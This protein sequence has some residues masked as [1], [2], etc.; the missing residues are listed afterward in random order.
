MHNSPTNNTIFCDASPS[1]HNTFA[2]D[3]TSP[4]QNLLKTPYGFYFRMKVPKR[5]REHFR[6]R[7]FKKALNTHDRRDAQKKALLLTAMVDEYIAQLDTAK[8]YKMSRLPFFTS[9]KVAEIEV[10]STGYKL[11]GIELDPLHYETDQRAYSDIRASALADSQALANMQHPNQFSPAAPA[12][13]A[14]QPCQLTSAV[15]VVQTAVETPPASA[16]QKLFAELIENFVEEKTVSGNWDALSSNGRKEQLLRALDYFGDCDVTLITR[17]DARRFMHVLAKLPP[18]YKKK[19]AFATLSLKEASKK[20]SGPTI[21]PKSVNMAMTD[22][23]SFFKWC[24]K[25]GYIIRNAFEGL[26]VKEKTIALTQRLPYTRPELTQLF[27]DKLF[28]QHCCEASEYFLP[29][30]GL[31][32]GARLNEL[33]QLHTNDIFQIEDVWVFEINENDAQKTIKTKES[34]RIL[35]IHPELIRLNFLQYVKSLKPGRVFPNLP[36]KKGKFSGDYSKR[37]GTVRNRVKIVDKDFHSFR[38]LVSAEL[39]RLNIPEH[40]VASILGHKHP[41]ITFARYGEPK[42][43]K[44]IHRIISKLRFDI[45]VP[46]WPAQ[47]IARGQ[48]L[49]KM[50]EIDP[51]LKASDS[52][53]DNVLKLNNKVRRQI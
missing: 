43:I 52:T 42:Y 44:R 18:N 25:C 24:V 3:N 47:K 17:D 5:H 30:L 1:L 14:S 7:E 11:K 33:C 9:M 4:G 21:S 51:S 45:A 22:I 46:A 31:Y 34:R 41:H 16:S 36:Y 37:F 8:G 15:Q 28:Q 40:I 39:E 49:Q 35:P 27:K 23:A 26:S 13:L 29:L 10:F 48:V 53:L 20:N 19:K 2:G 32:H 38:H 12:F 50:R 6:R